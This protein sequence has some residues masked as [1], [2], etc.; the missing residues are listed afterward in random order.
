M[1][2]PLIL[3]CCLSQILAFSQA[4]QWSWTFDI[5]RSEECSALAV[6]A[7]GNTIMAGHFSSV[8]LYEAGTQFEDL[9]NRN[10]F[11]VK[12][13]PEGETVWAMQPLTKTEPNVWVGATYELITDKEDNIY[14][15]G[16]FL[17]TISYGDCMM[18]SNAGNTT[19][20][21]YIAKLNP[22]GECEWM[23]SAVSNQAN[24]MVDLAVDSEQNVYV[25]GTLNGSLDFGDLSISENST[26]FTSYL[27]KMDKEG[28]S[29]WAKHALSGDSN[30]TST[31]DIKEDRLFMSL[32]YSGSCQ[33]GGGIFT[34]ELGS[35]GAVM[36]LDL[37]GNYLWHHSISL[38]NENGA[39]YLDI[40]D[41]EATK[42]GNIV[43]TGVYR[44]DAL[45]T[46]NIELPVIN[47]W[48]N[49]VAYADESEGIQWML[50]MGYID[51]GAYIDP[52]LDID[53][54]GNIY[55]TSTYQ[56]SLILDFHAFGAVGSFDIISARIGPGGKVDWAESFGSESYDDGLGVVCDH[57][58]NV[59]IAGDARDVMA[60]GPHIIAPQGGVDA[61]ISKI[62][63]EES[64]SNVVD[65]LWSVDLS[66]HPNP[67]VD[68]LHIENPDNQLLQV[69]LLSMDGK[70][71]MAQTIRQDH[72]MK[73]DHLS[74]GSYMLHIK[75]LSRQMSISKKIIKM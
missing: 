67:C 14:I 59:F 18:T 27:L 30:G 41:L 10:Y 73:V 72:R 26:G 66:I 49:Y 12:V 2:L 3:I 54:V 6:D 50:P 33:F 65:G 38:K 55:F 44:D 5:S 11:L 45:V 21:G 1:K 32:L 15:A 47:D 9:T 20:Q 29:L 37:E 48:A 8:P 58:G 56:D 51:N 43:F 39:G 17:D 31:M 25:N 69:D 53:P 71:L 46:E 75:D 16:T 62:F 22:D 57:Q 63:F 23:K 19:T 35:T 61:F 68:V 7:S 36:E 60:I 13:N 74:S 24:W 34:T 42:E 52:D 28:N 4:H 70:L 64:L 40:G